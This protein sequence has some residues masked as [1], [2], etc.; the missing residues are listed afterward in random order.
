MIPKKFGPAAVAI[1]SAA[2]LFWSC[3][4]LTVERFHENGIIATASPIATGIGLNILETGG[5]AT[6]AAVAVAFALAVCYPKAAN[7]GGGG[8]ALIY[9]PQ[10]SVVSA[11]DFRETAP[12]KAAAGIYLDESGNVIKDASLVGAKAAG[13]PGTVAGLYYLW[14]RYGSMDWARLLEPAIKLADTGFVVTEQLAES[15]ARYHDALAQFPETR[16]VF[17]SG[18]RPL[19]CG[20]RLIQKD[21]AATLERIS[22]DTTAG[23]YSGTTADLIVRTME[24]Y[25]GLID[26]TDLEN[27]RPVWREPIHF[28]FDSLDVYSMPPPS[29]GGVI[30]GEIL[31]LIESYDFS[32]YTVGSADYIHLFAEACR[33]AYADRAVQLGDPDFV[34]NPIDELLSQAYIQSRRTLIDMARAGNSLKTESGLS[35]LKP[36]T[37][38][39][40]HFSIADS[41]GNIVSLTYTINTDFGSKLVVKGA[42]FLLNNEMDDFAVKS[43][44]PNF[45]NLVGSKANEIAPGKRMLS[46]MA[47]TIIMKK[48]KPLLVL[49]APGGSKI[50][51]TVAEVI[52]DV[53]R[54]GLNL[55]EAVRQP[56][57]H[58]QWLPDTLYLEMGG[59]D[60]NV[61]QDLISRGHTV[62]EISP[63]SDVQAIYFNIDGLMTGASDPRGS[64]AVDGF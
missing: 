3:N 53:I 64:G 9:D 15:V 4:S 45:Y 22:I 25:G 30:M 21:L 62:K 26:H 34:D 43:G 5:N 48:G 27:Y 35:R 40:T 57:F 20:G 44:V 49:G 41:S 37:G 39:T 46:S 29:S 23:F 47:P 13:V 31:K 16:A 8:F 60:V 38:S 1:I 50:I 11:L 24:T 56:R 17:F 12:S 42:G 55:K 7:I 28:K 59:F 51:T 6:D 61:M 14:R 58:H 2:V 33:L 54:F 10:D 19:R 18:D 63:Y 32:S 36:E 52:I